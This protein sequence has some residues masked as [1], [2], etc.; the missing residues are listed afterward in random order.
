GSS[1]ANPF[2][3]VSAGIA[4][5][6]GPAHG[7]ANESV[8]RMALV[9]RVLEARGLDVTPSMMERDIGALPVVDENRRVVGV[10]SEKHLMALFSDVETHVRVGEIMTPCLITLPP[11]AS[12]LE[13]QKIM[14]TNDIRRLVLKT[15]TGLKGILT[16]MD[17]ISFYSSEKTLNMLK[18]KRV[19]EVHATPLQ[20]L[21]PKE[22]VTVD[23][24]EDIGRAIAIMRKH[25]IGHLIVG[26]GQGI[27]TERD[28]LLKLPKVIGVDVFVD[29][30]R[31]LISAG[32]IFFY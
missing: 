29:D 9:P 26:D 6:W 12:V 25:G 21:D 2:A 31:K 14:I 5:L 16:I 19:K 7:G 15:T 30:V 8:I 20:A 23:P 13:G 22:I 10:I 24:L 28:F 18:E 3:A 27:I 4:S 1:E 17:L 32:R 11:Q